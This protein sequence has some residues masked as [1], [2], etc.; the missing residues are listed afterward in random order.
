MRWALSRSMVSCFDGPVPR[1]PNRSSVEGLILHDLI[2]HYYR[3]TI[4]CAS[5]L[6]RPRKTLLALI[7][8]WANDNSNNPRIDS[9]AMAGQLRIEEILRAFV[10]VCH[11][12]R[13]IEHQPMICGAPA[14]IRKGTLN[15][16]ERLLRDPESKLCGRVDLI[17]EGEII[18]FKSGEQQQ[19]HSEQLLF[20][21]ALYLAMTKRLP[22]GCRLIYTATNQSRDVPVPLLSDLNSLL[23]RIRLQANGAEK[24]ISKGELQAN[25]QLAR[26]MYCH[27]RGLCV[28]YWS[29]I[30]EPSLDDHRL[31]TSILDYSPSKV[32]SVERAAFGV[33]LRDKVCG[34]PSLLHL[35]QDV[36]EKAGSNIG[37]IRVLALR[38]SVGEGLLH[39]AF[40]QASEIFIPNCDAKG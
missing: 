12:L 39:F 2:E 5:Q 8:A 9:H 40:T 27:V 34:L 29:W 36:V 28:A 3:E 24:R 15:G 35:P 22:S 21:G 38:P 7:V 23:D 31:Q 18:D 16:S 14:L 11:H 13:K 26:C 25:P 32:V 17:S 4:N 1:K 6:F 20:Y 37:K 10:E 30:K 33:Y 19:H